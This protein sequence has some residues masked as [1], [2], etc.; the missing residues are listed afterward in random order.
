MNESPLSVGCGTAPLEEVLPL[1][2][3]F[4]RACV[5]ATV[6][7]YDEANVGKPEVVDG[8]EVFDLGV[9]VSDGCSGTTP[10]HIATAVAEPRVA[11]EARRA[12]RHARW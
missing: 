8:E 5:S 10:A 1:E 7:L 6:T 4:Q 12:P 2:L 3:S 11:G 9:T